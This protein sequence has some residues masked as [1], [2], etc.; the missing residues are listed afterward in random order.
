M[1][2]MLS[3]SNIYMVWLFIELMFL[4]F[5]LVVI[6]GEVKRVGL[7]IY[8]FFQSIMSLLMFIVLIIRADKLIFILM[9]AKLGLFPFFY[10]MVVVS[11]KVGFLGN[12][13][14]LSLQ[15]FSV[16]WIIWLFIKSRVIFV[17]FIMYLRVFFVIISLLIISD[18]WLLLVYSSI[19]NTAIIVLR[20]YGSLFFSSIFL[21]LC[22]V[23]F[24]IFLIKYSYSYLEVVLIVMLFLVIPPFLLFF[25]KLYVVLSM[26]FFF[27]VSFLFGSFWCV[28]FVILL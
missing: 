5:L 23:L 28:S 19:S 22:I 4:F 3:I 18:L 2:L 8:F 17:Y 16:F 11:L 7:I 13:F 14:V 25:M 12:F 24:I 1:F 9:L 15:K 10:W 27:K 26:D 21:Y 20:I 6:L